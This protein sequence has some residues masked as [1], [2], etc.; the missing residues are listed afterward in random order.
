MFQRGLFII[1]NNQIDD[2]IIIYLLIP[3]STLCITY[4]YID[5]ERGASNRKRSLLTCHHKLEGRTDTDHTCEYQSI[6]NINYQSL[7]EYVC[8]K[9]HCFII[10]HIFAQL[11]PLILL[12]ACFRY[13]HGLFMDFYY[14]FRRKKYS[15]HCF[16]C[17][18]FIFDAKY[19]F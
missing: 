11:L 8:K 19:P 15:N 3:G 9:H 13:Y 14:K 17:Y 5:R 2:S 16:G 12:F 4:A 10:L 7:A 18:D 1:S 6:I